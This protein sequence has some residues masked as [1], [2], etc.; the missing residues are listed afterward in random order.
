MTERRDMGTESRRKDLSLDMVPFRGP[1]WRGVPTVVGGAQLA[2]KHKSR[3]GALSKKVRVREE[4]RPKKLTSG[5][6]LGP[7]YK[8]I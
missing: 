4:Q 1:T 5:Q 3:D 2:M 8:R 6:T 7:I